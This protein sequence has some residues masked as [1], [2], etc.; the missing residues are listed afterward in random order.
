MVGRAVGR[1]LV[2][3]D[4]TLLV[5]GSDRRRARAGYRSTMSAAR[6]EEW[7]R[8]GPGGLPWWRV[9]RPPRREDGR[10]LV[11][12]EKRPRIGMDGLSTAPVRPRIELE[13]FLEI[14]AGVLGVSVDDL[15]GR[16]REARI[17]EARRILAWLGVE[18]YGY[19]VKAVAEGLGKHVETTSR[20][21]SRAAGQ[22]VD[23]EAFRARLERVDRVIS[24]SGRDE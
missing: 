1:R 2:D 12:D 17:V 18:L 16:R 24:L 9:G 19:F 8:S 22:R 20:L 11:I 15:H 13:D 7:S 5:F 14:G 21:V 23:D 4:E 10:D 6:G 3:V